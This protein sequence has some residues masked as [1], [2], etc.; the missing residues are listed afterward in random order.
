[1]IKPISDEQVMIMNLN[2]EISTIKA[3]L[4]DN[5]KNITEV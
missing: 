5:Q 1:V 3:I 2:K 4:N